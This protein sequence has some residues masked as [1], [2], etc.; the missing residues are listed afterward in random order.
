M[1]Q[2][3]QPLQRHGFGPTTDNTAAAAVTTNFASYSSTATTIH[4]NSWSNS[5]TEN[6]PVWNEEWKRLGLGASLVETP[7]FP[8][9][10]FFVQLGFG[11]DQH[12]DRSDATKAA[13]RAVRNAIEFNSIPGVINHIP[14]GRKKMLIHVKLGVPGGEKETSQA[15]VNPLEV[16][17]VFPY[18]K[19]LPIQVTTG[20]LE[21]H[22]GRVVE[23]LGDQDDVGI[24]CVACVSIGYNDNDN[25]DDNDDDDNDDNDD[26]DNSTTT[27]TTTTSGH[28]TYNTKDGY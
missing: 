16:A 23:E 15:V 8:P 4:K 26:N 10:L 19:L 20:G 1:R 24:C 14:G 27:T 18:G 3:Q 12:G 25:D 21:F 5:T 9:N 11:V 7:Q 17:K 2:Q 22:S 13:V 6:R 28:K